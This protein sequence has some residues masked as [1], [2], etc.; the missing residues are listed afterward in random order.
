MKYSLA[1]AI[2][3]LLAVTAM[4]Q[5]NSSNATYDCDPAADECEEKWGFIDY[6]CANHKQDGVSYYSCWSEVAVST[7]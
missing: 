1:L 5:S 2:L 4:G 7:T 6:C 3:A